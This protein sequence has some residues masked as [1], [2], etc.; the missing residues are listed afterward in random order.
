[1]IFDFDNLTPWGEEHLSSLISANA[2]QRGLAPIS[3]LDWLPSANS[4]P[5]CSNLLAQEVAEEAERERLGTE[6]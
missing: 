2:H 3:V 6:C 4:A 5:S 1:M